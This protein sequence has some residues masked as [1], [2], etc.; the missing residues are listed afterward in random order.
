MAGSN[1]FETRD[2]ARLHYLDVG[3]G[4]AVILLPGWSQ[5]AAM[6]S[7]QVDALSERYRVI[8]LDHRG[9]G[10]SDKCDH[11]YRV[12]KL[13][14]D[15]RELILALQLNQI[16]ILGHSMGGAVIFA[17]FD[18]FGSDRLTKVILDD[19][20]AALTLS[21]TETSKAQAEA[22]M[23][24]TWDQLGSLCAAFRGGEAM[25]TTR[26]MLEGMLSKRLYDEKMDWILAENIKLPRQH[27]ATLLWDCALA[28][29]RE[30]IGRI[31]VPTLVIGGKASVVPW[32]S[33]QWIAQQVT[34]SECVILEEEQGGYHFAFLE[35]PETFNAVI[36]RF[37]NQR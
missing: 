31:D 23:I 17:Y 27:A 24:F 37:L 7:G 21:D 9:H 33:Q 19:Q 13:A 3:R 1:W 16:A 34:Q 6:F 32:Q 15:L 4:P 29:W 10:E 22:G 20:P 36:G 2:G 28:D 18:L 5:T 11:G 25:Q 26:Q 35:S 14:M 8:A 12:Y 30:V